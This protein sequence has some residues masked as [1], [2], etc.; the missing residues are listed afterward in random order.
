ML[1]CSPNSPVRDFR[2]KGKVIMDFACLRRH[3]ADE[4]AVLRE[5][6]RWWEHECRLLRDEFGGLCTQ[7]EEGRF[8]VRLA[9]LAV[10]EVWW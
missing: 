5:L 6:G 7:S 9:A 8:S 1:L 10:S 4:S 3:D 2:T